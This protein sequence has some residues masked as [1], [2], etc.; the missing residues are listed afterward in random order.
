MTQVNLHNKKSVHS[1]ANKIARLAWYC[2]WVLLF[3]PTP[4]PLH[5]WRRFL[6]R[7]FGAK[8]HSTS[9]IYP[10][11]KIWAPWNLTMGECATI[12]DNVDCYSV[13]QIMIGD[14]TTISQYSYLCAAT[15]DY[16][17]PRFPLVP[18]PIRIGSQCWIAADVFVAPG[19]QVGDGTVVGARSSVFADL[20]EWKVCVGNPARPVKQRVLVK[21]ES[22]EAD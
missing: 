10:K 17:H 5:V 7:C 14:H 15:H 4:R 18:K 16:T 19:V 2:V 1:G 13:D 8:L 6:L 12:S 3:L 11:A 22:S 20:P 9:R 21:G